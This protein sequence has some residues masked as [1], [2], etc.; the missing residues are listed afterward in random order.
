MEWNGDQFFDNYNSGTYNNQYMVVDYNKFK[1][2]VGL[3]AG[4]LVVVEQIPGLIVYADQTTQLERGYW[5][6]YNIPF[7]P[8]IYNLSGYPEVYQSQGWQASYQ[9]CPRC[10]I[11]RRDQGNVIDLSS[12]Q[13]TMRYNNYKNDPISRGD[14]GNSIC[15]RFDLEIEDPAPFG[16]TDTKVTSVELIASLTSYAI[17]GPTTS[18]NLPPFQWT[19]EFNSTQHFGEPHTFDFDFIVMNPQWED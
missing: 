2:G 12:F 16:C 9:V 4:A 19:A 14:P 1:A 11:F 17:S 10:Q 7:Y 8:I 6:S 5:A 15:S 18:N 13:S 3:S